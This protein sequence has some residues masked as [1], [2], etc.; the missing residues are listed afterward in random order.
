MNTENG[1][2]PQLLAISRRI[3]FYAGACRRRLKT[4]PP[5]P[6]LA[7]RLSGRPETVDGKDEDAV[8]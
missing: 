3:S 7:D 2:R 4:G 6:A 5:A 1:E 8:F